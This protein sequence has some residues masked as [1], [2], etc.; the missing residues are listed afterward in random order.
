MVVYTNYSIDAR[1]RREA[2]TL[3]D[4]PDYKVLVLTL[5]QKT[6][7][8]TSFID[9]VEVRELNLTKYRGKSNIRYLISYFRFLLLAFLACTRLLIRNSLDVVHVH[10]MPNFLVFSAIIP[11]L[12]G[13]KIILDVHDTVVET[14]LSKFD[15]ASSKIF[16]K[17]LY[18]ALRLE[19]SI[20]CALAHK[21]ICVNHIQREALIKRG[22][23]ENKMIISMNVPDPRR[24]HNYN[25]ITDLTKKNSFKVV[26]FGTITKRLGIDLAIRAVASLNGRIPG[27]EFH[28]IGEG[29]DKEEFIKLSEEL[30]IKEVMHFYETLFPL[31]DLVK[32]LEGMD[33]GIVPNR[34]NAATELMLPVKMLEC[35]ALSIPVIVPRLKTIEYYFSDELVFYFE[36]DNVESLSSAILDVFNNGTMRTKKAENAKG[37]LK[38]YGWETH[39]FDLIN[40]YRSLLE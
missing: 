33:L 19:E 4:L 17:I 27:L 9:N 35:I 15:G 13:K 5:K 2:E 22:I 11:F 30:G 29:D 38:K 1:V 8:R 7:P 3:A 12:F 24:F 25:R 37:F 31:E 16:H 28:I 21:I 6:S 14:Y 18:K 10:N 36:P 23:P 26:Y 32:I 40:L 34:K 20:C 39:K